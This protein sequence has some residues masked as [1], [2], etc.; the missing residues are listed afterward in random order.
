MLKTKTIL[1]FG[2][3]SGIGKYLFEKLSQD[4]KLK[5]IGF[6]SKK[7][8]IKKNIFFYEYRK[9]KE[10]KKTLLDLSK[11]ENKIY[12]IICNGT[13]GE[14][15]KFEKINFKKFINTFNINFFSVAEIV[16][17][18]FNIFK[19]KKKFVLVFSGGGTFEN[20]P[21]FDAYA[22][23][24]TSLV[25]FVENLAA[26]YKKNELQ[27]N[28]VAPG[29]NFG[30]I[31]KNLLKSYSKE[32]IGKSYYNFMKRNMN[33]KNSFDQ[34]FKFV[35]KIILNNFFNL[36]GKTISINFDD[37]DKKKFDKNLKIINKSDYMCLR[38]INKK[39]Y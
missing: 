9:T 1:I 13:T 14:I 21:R 15:G 10:L 3:S 2:V 36:N 27:I 39:P 33:K 6:T 35:Q 37:W 32:V 11:T 25:R 18:Y 7:K 19:N 31:H 26:E 8:H 4:K 17:N 16:Y 30:K 20:F 38:R 29:F 22:S 34:I 23:S 28:A 24:K 12:L 5:L